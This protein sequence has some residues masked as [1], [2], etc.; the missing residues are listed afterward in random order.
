MQLYRLVCHFFK[1]TCLSK[2]I[3]YVCK[4]KYINIMSIRLMEELSFP[5]GRTWNLEP[6]GIYIPFQLNY[7]P[8][9]F[10][11]VDG[12]GMIVG[13]DLTMKEWRGTFRGNALHCW[14]QRLRRQSYQDFHRVI[15]VSPWTHAARSADFSNSIYRRTS[16]IR[17]ECG[18]S[19]FL[20]LFFL[21]GSETSW[22][23]ER[24]D[25]DTR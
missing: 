11:Y 17:R 4:K 10:D 8:R 5:H 3:W 15:I 7:I 6:A 1:L 18:N 12:N 20:I 19:F 2:L 25:D 21:I 23:Q 24:L 9:R 16:I 22:H 14:G 13:N